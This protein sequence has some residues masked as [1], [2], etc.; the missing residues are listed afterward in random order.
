MADFTKQFDDLKN[1][2]GGLAEKDLGEFATQ[3]KADA[4]AFLEESRAQLEKWFKQL[5]SGEIDEEELRELVQTQTDLGK[6][7]ALQE[8]SAG[9]QKIDSFRD[10]ALGLIVKTALSAIPTDNQSSS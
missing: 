3:G 9:Q 10:S 6:M 7:R 2:L 5:A 4:M 8:A 1:Q